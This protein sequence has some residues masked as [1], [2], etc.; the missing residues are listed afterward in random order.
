MPLDIKIENFQGPFDVLLHLIKKNEMD[1][2][3]IKIY[4]ITN[5]YLQYLDQ[6]KSM[7]LEITSEF[8]VIAATLIEIKSKML[9]PKA[10]LDE[11]AVTEEEDPRKVLVQKL[12]E[13]KKYKAV[14]A[15]L[16]NLEGSAGVI[17]SK[18]PE[19]IVEKD[20]VIDNSE[21]FK[22]I[23]MLT[24][25]NLYNE[26]INNY[27]SKQNTE[28]VIQKE[29]PVDLYKIEDKMEELRN[30][31]DNI[32]KVYFTSVIK[33]CTSKIEV[34]VTFL[35]MLE[36]IKQRGARAWQEENFHD[37]YLERINEDEEL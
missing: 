8:I 13:Y 20:K 26:L 34:V 7:N 24:L 18:R 5:Q 12:I 3:D 16:R 10:K 4:E 36:L 28:N 1:I 2:Y 11:T 35:A 22:G 23:T 37:I 29:I 33:K 32:E 17:F 21:L 31:L 9:L 15:V 25:F 14:A 19:I 6:F 30:N 27:K